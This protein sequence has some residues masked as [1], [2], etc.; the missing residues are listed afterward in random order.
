MSHHSARRIISTIVVATALAGALV[1]GAG[2]AAAD[3][4]DSAGSGAGEFLD[5]T[6][7][8]DLQLNAASVSLNFCLV[9]RYFL[10]GNADFCNLDWDGGELG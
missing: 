7:V 8:Q 4:I 6:S 10:P 5:T 3:G 2:S 1:G 9:A